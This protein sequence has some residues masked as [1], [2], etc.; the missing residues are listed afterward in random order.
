MH[1]RGKEN[2]KGQKMCSSMKII[3]YTIRGLGCVKKRRLVWEC[4]SKYKPSIMIIQ[5]TKKEVTSKL[6]VKSSVCPKLFEWCV[7]LAIG[8][9]G[10]VLIAW[11]P[12]EILKV[13]EVVG[14]FTVSIKIIENSSGFEWMLFGV[15]RPCKP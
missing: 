4:V 13:D 11:D 14:N 9:C 6:L 3:T 5:E 10:G 2:Y 1:R 15:Y 7:L 8:T 12:S